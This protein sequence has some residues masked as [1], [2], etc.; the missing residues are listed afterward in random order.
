MDFLLEIH[1]IYWLI[2]V[3]DHKHIL[4]GP[5][6][7]NFKINIFVRV[8][9]IDPNSQRPNPRAGNCP[10]G[11]WLKDVARRK[12]PAITQAKKKMPEII[13]FKLLIITVFQIYFAQL[14]SLYT[15]AWSA[16]PGR[17]KH[18]RLFQAFRYNV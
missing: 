18:F 14:N 12:L 16:R 1:T 3:C 5:F 11:K 9:S 7:F 17:R 6:H 4:I 13:Y 15:Y 8:A 10:N 2:K